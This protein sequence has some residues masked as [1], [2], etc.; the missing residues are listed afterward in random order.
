MPFIHLGPIKLESVQTEYNISILNP[1]SDDGAYICLC[2]ST[3]SLPA[4]YLASTSF[5]FQG[6]VL[7]SLPLRSLPASVY[8]RENKVLYGA[9]HCSILKHT[10]HSIMHYFGYFLLVRVS[11]GKT[12][13]LH[14]FI[15]LKWFYLVLKKYLRVLEW[16][17]WVG[18]LPCTQMT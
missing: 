7:L 8:T 5:T 2:F 3:T 14:F 9:C 16:V 11:Y 6:C 13:S 12:K 10:A 18:Q 4:L 17:Q 1:L 15:Y